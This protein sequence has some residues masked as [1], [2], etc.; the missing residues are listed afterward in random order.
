[1]FRSRWAGV[2]LRGALVLEAV[3]EWCR[4]V[5]SSNRART[6]FAQLSLQVVAAILIDIL[7]WFTRGR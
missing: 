7:A 1:M 5:W 2:R 3:R 6:W 4:S